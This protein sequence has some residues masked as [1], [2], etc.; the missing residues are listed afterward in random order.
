MD[1]DPQ[2]LL[3]ANFQLDARTLVF[4]LNIKVLYIEG[5][6][7][8]FEGCFQNTDQD[9]MVNY[10]FNKVDHCLLLQG[11]LNLLNRE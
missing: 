6:Q 4:V 3:V 7:V 5:Y 8:I 11:P 9:Q 1:L 10:F 2:Q